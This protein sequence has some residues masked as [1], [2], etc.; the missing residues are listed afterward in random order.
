[1]SGR[2][3]KKRELAGAGLCERL[4]GGLGGEALARGGVVP[5]VLL[6][7]EE[8]PAE[9]ERSG[10]RGGATGEGVKD[11]VTRVGEV[12]DQREHEVE[13]L[14]GGMVALRMPVA[15]AI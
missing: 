2:P 5:G 14:G 13:R 4:P 11:E 3:L 6:C 7:S 8:A 15:V 12:S 1:M 10:T 9:T